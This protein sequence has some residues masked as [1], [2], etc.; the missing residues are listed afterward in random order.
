MSTH[1]RVWKYFIK[2]KNGQ[3]RCNIC[4]KRYQHSGNTSNLRKHLK[5]AHN[6][7]PSASSAASSSVSGRSTPSSMPSLSTIDSIFQDVSSMQSGD[8]KEKITNAI[9]IMIVKDN[10]PFDHVGGSGFELLMKEL[11]PH[12]Q[13]PNRKSIGRRIDVLYDEMFQLKQAEVSAL[14]NISIT[15]DLWKDTQNQVSYIGV[16]GHYIKD[17]KLNS[18]LLSCMNMAVRHTSANIIN[19]LNEVLES[20]KIEHNQVVACVTDNGANVKKA[21]CDLFG[22]AR[23]IPCFA[24]TLNLLVKDAINRTGNFREVLQKVRTIVQYFKQSGPAADELRKVQP[25]GRILKLKQDVETR[26]NSSYLMLN[27]YIE[28][29][30]SVNLALSH[31]IDAPSPITGAEREI[32]EDSLKVL[33]PFYLITEEMSAEK[34]VTLSKAIPIRNILTN[35]LKDIRLDTQVAS[36]LKQQ[37]ITGLDER[38]SNLESNTSAIVASILDPRFKK[39]YVE[40]LTSY[41]NAIVEIEKLLPST[42]PPMIESIDDDSQDEDD[43]WTSHDRL[44]STQH[45]ADPESQSINLSTKLKLYLDANLT[46][47]KVNPLQTWSKIESTFWEISQIAPIYLCIPATSV[48]SERLFSKAGSTL[49]EKRNRLKPETLNKI[50]FLNS[51]T[52]RELRTILNKE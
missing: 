35:K 28:I 6:K 38:F 40:S 44:A 19:S 29:Q 13:V 3:A 17:W 46:N 30:D 37:L 15:F 8:K 5:N 25:M 41:P 27:R 45:Q 36:F 47:R 39:F 20:W 31:L 16:T 18:V 1:S 34:V 4:Y 24:H 12:Y 42:S 10:L 2:E 14:K 9:T 11:A 21:V 43:V 26:W 7:D 51:L 22:Q 32:L 49:N 52:I 23:H 48:P 50:L 33:K